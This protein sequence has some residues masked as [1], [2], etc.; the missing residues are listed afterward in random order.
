MKFYRRRVQVGQLG[1]TLMLLWSAVAWGA[2]IKDVESA[3]HA[4]TAA[5]VELVNT[6]QGTGYQ[7]LQFNL[8]VL[9]HYSYLLVSGKEALVIDPD[10]DIDAYLEA[11]RKA[12]AEIK[13][14]FL[15]HSH[16]DFVAGH[17]ELTKAI[18]CPIYF[19][20]TSAPL[21]P[22]QSIKDGSVIRVG[23]AQIKILET[24]GH[25]PDGLCGVISAKSVPDNPEMMF[26][27]D[28]LFV[29]S[30][31]RPDLMG[32][33]TSAAELA[34]M[35]FD[36]WNQKLSKLPDSVK[37]LPAHGAG[38]LCGAHLSDDPSST[39]GR[40]RS[41][42]AYLKHADNR[43]AFISGVLDG[44]PEAPQYFKHNAKMNHDG[45][46]LVNW[47]GPLAEPASPSEELT[48]ISQWFVVDL[49]GA[50]EFADGHIPNS[51]NIAL[52][53]RLET[54]VGIIVPWGSNVL[55][56]GSMDEIT[57]ATHRLHRVGYRAGFITW[58]S[59]KK[60]GLPQLR[61]AMIKPADLYSQMQKGKAPI[62]V[63]V[64]LPSEWMGLRIGP[65][66]NLPLNQLGELAPTKLN[67]QEPVVAVCNSA[68]RSSLAVGILERVGFKLA[69][70][71]DGGS[72]AWI[73]A[74]F[75]VIQAET[76]AG[77]VSEGT[78]PA[79]L[80]QINL[81]DRLS[82]AELKRLVIDLP[83]FFEVVDLRPA[84]QAA[85][86]N[87]LGARAVDVIEVMT[88]PVFLVGDIPLIIVDRD[89][90]IAL[91]VA[92]ILSQKTKRPIKVLHGGMEAY[93]AE[94]ELQKPGLLPGVMPMKPLSGASDGSV[95]P[96]VPSAPGGS[97]G[98]V[99]P[100][101]PTPAE[102]AK[103]KKKSAGC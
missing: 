44:L 43:S 42:N 31:G 98:P 95:A 2:G 3:S 34:G 99:S 80:R 102:P 17:M 40:E 16:A 74:G 35:M 4:D 12:G 53:G 11:V 97:V 24:P 57:E 56:C 48:K 14:V 45:P 96:L 50:K 58:D 71:M 47:R 91:M 66:L 19:S 6:Y 59:W 94:S 22:H 88:N 5:L 1:I 18:G 7:V 26:S 84:L 27:G 76:S 21:Y 92:G 9:S 54:W 79:R 87:P 23:E 10:R 60:A 101:T 20:D 67:R 77:A 68:Y 89:G 103:P 51:V 61:N 100:T 15:S 85:D 81:P 13:G 37:V 78:E 93:W 64:R 32:G 33:T 72:E 82:P 83:G 30:V 39:I 86:Y 38:S 65:V 63:D 49:R 8:A 25:T 62:I 90:S 46:E 55:L 73:E 52:R 29:G 75:P 70:S 36:T 41:S 28:T 69:T